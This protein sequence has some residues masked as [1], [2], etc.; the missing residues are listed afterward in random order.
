MGFIAVVLIVNKSVFFF[1]FAW[2]YV[3]YDTI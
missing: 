1:P 2:Y 3:G